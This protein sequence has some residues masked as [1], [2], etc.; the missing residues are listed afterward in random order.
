MRSPSPSSSSYIASSPSTAPSTPPPGRP[1]YCIVT[2]DASV[3]FLQ[4]L[5]VA[6]SS[7]DRAL[8]FNGAG[9]VKDLLSQAADILEDKSILE[10]ARWERVIAQD[11]G[12][13]VEYYQTKSGQSMLEVSDDKVSVVLD[14]VKV[15][16]KPIAHDDALNRF[17][18]A[19]LRSMIVLH[20]PSS[21]ATLY[22]LERPAQTYPLLSSAPAT[23]LNP[24]AHPFNIPSLAEFE[25][26]WTTWDLITLGMIPPSLLHAK[27]IDLRHKPLFYIGHLPTFANILLSRLTN[28]REVGPRHFLTT[29]ERGIDPIVDDPDA[30][31]SHSEV[32]EKDEDWPALGEVLAYR[33]EVRERV[34]RRVYSEMESGERAL[35]RRMART[36]MMVL[37]HDG[38]HIETLLYM[39]IQRAGTGTLPPPGFAAPPWEALAAQW[40]TLSA[41]TTPTVTLGPCELVMGHDDQEPDDLDAALEHAVA[42]HEFGWDNESPR[43]AVH[44]GRFSVDWR[45]VTNGEFEAFWRGAGKDKVEMPPSWV[46]ED[47]AVKVRTLYGP[48]PMAIAR[49]WPV[50]TAYDDLAAFAAH[51]GGRIPTEPELR[52]FLDTYQ[53]TYAEG[54]NVGF[55][56]WHPLPATAGGAARGGRGSNGGVWE[57]TAT[58]LDGHEGFA[59]T[60]IFPGYSSDFFDGKHQVVLGA[61]YATIPRLA[62]RRTVRNFYQHN[63]PYPWVGARVAYDA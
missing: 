41:P 22:I 37:E 13:E 57:W 40:D 42:D 34:I 21:T 3:A 51:K 30:C 54:A 11:G 58:A 1:T 45:P 55:R 47:G 10:D 14:A 9:S 24:T 59:G 44:V 50:L 49:H 5:R 29:F 36:L 52:L 23:T 26:G 20:N 25:R 62:D 16:T 60:G 61:S 7:G 35:T 12:A 33:D 4:T 63:Y 53:D 27:P 32:P 46:E 56:H 17:C 28:A 48:V 2:H 31:H 8:L 38:F 6:K 15:Q 18:E 43:R 19:G 39:L